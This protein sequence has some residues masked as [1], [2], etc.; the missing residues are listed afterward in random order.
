[1]NQKIKDLNRNIERYPYILNENENLLSIIFCTKN[2]KILFSM[3]CKSTDNIK[4]LESKIYKKYP[5]ISCIEN[6]FTFKGKIVDKKESPE[7]N[8]INDGDLIT[9]NH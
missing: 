6:Y 1:M 4:I 3:V 2:E 7:K 8:N 5:E 9:I